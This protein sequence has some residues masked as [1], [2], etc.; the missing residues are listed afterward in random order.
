[1]ECFPFFISLLFVCEFYDVIGLLVL[2]SSMEKQEREYI[3]WHL[4]MNY[5]AN[6]ITTDNFPPCS[7]VSLNYK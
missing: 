6:L 5:S 3:F 4:K 1:M 7:S 2:M